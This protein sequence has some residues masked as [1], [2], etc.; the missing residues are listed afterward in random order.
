MSWSREEILLATGGKILREGKE[1]VFDEVVIDSHKVKRGAI[2]VALKGQRFDGH[3]FLG[4]AARRGATC[5]IVHQRPANSHL[6]D[7]TAVRVGDTLKA[8]GDLALYRRLAVAPEVLAITGSNGKTT[9]KEMVAAILECASIEGRSLRSRVLKTEGNYNNLVGLPLTLLRLRGRERVVVLEMGTSSPGEI[10]RLCKIAKP[11]MG[12]ITSIAPA[13][14]TGLRNIAGVAREKGDLFREL[15][16]RGIAVV[17]VDDPWV[18]RL[19]AKFKGQKVTYGK[20]GEVRAEG[21]R[22]LGAKGTEFTLRVGGKRQRA[23]LRLCGGHNLSNAV[24]AAAMAYGFGVDLE[25]ICAG[26]EAVRPLR[27]RMAIESWRG[28]GII[29]DAYNANPVSME[30]ALKSLAEIEAKGRIIAILGDMLELGGEARQSHLVL[31]KQVARYGI[32]HL[33]LLGEWAAQVKEG[34]LRAGMEEERV[35]IGKS[36]RQIAR[37]V[38]SEARKGDWLLLKGSRGMKMERVLAALKETGV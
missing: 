12:L 30:A 10:W 8:L 2:F 13:H 4:A 27:M 29:N 37:M 9:T 7:V 16:S 31:G 20:R 17:N 3:Q 14:L 6:G 26:L 28:I 24:G 34:A 35:T 19:G 15:D 21:W 22:F 23:R 5:L 1:T 36:H 11:D 38:G 32:E 33:Y 25:A 18:R